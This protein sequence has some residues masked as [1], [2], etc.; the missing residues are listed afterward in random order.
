MLCMLRMPSALSFASTQDNPVQ[1]YWRA[2][3]MA[4]WQ[5]VS[6]DNIKVSQIPHQD[7]IQFDLHSHYHCGLKKISIW[8][9]VL[10]ILFQNK[11]HEQQQWNQTIWY[12]IFFMSSEKSRRKS[13][14]TE[15][16]KK[17]D[18]KMPLFSLVL[19][20]SSDRLERLLQVQSLNLAISMRY[21]QRRKKKEKLLLNLHSKINLRPAPKL[22]SFN[23]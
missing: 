13:H 6:W 2:M 11:G 16:S 8:R 18:F 12:T 17:A 10:L 15:N 14:P 3:I 20:F 7:T 5:I 9:Q 21:V 23:I 22:Y 19:C 1:Y 4:L